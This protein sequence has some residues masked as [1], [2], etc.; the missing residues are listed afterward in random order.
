MKIV[1]RIRHPLVLVGVVLSL[2]LGVATIRAAALWTAASAPLAARPPS[3]GSLQAALAT[4]RVRSAT[5]QAQ[6]DE[7]TSRS[8]ELTAALETARDSIAAD[9]GQADK[10]RTS[11]DR[12]RAKL[13]LLEQSIRRS[14]TARSSTA[15]PAPTVTSPGTEGEAADDD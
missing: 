13:A 11:L 14:G 9:A 5:L 2:F 6:L 12:A 7:L 15:A 1:A 8:D 4:E 3:V 10:L